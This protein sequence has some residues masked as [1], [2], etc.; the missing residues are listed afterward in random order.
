LDNY[1]ATAADV[2]VALEFVNNDK[3]FYGKDGL[4]AKG[5]KF[6]LVGALKVG[7]GTGDLT[8]PAGIPQSGNERVFI[9]DFM[10]TAEF[11][12]D[13]GSDSPERKPSLQ[14][15]Y[16]VIP[17]LRSTQMLFGLSVNLTWASGKKYNINL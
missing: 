8:W 15:A 14:N 7:S 13:N 11:T 5:Q 6:Y 3:D 4:I 17:D 16:S 2:N 10:T 9:Q 1:Q 12:I